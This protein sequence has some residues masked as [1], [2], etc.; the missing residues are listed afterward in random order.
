MSSGV[1][2]S[3]IGASLIS[4]VDDDGGAGC[5]QKLSSVPLGHLGLVLAGLVAARSITDSGEH[6]LGEVALCTEMKC[7]AEE[8]PHP[9]AAVATC[10]A[11]STQKALT[12]HEV[13]VLLGDRAGGSSCSPPTLWWPRACGRAG[14]HA[15]AAALDLAE[16]PRARTRRTPPSS[17]SRQTTATIFALQ[18]LHQGAAFESSASHSRL[19]RARIS[20]RRGASRTWTYR[21]QFAG[22]SL[23]GH[24]SIGAACGAASRLPP[25][26]S[27]GRGRS[28]SSDEV[29]EAVDRTSPGL[30]RWR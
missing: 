7:A 28:P 25:S 24:G 23:A 16:L 12:V 4:F 22:S 29:L 21:F 9:S 27:F 3:L 11:K 14:G 10:L 6:H 8:R 15:P 18:A 1:L 2:S 17:C 19:R 26:A 13:G 20:S 5:L 30:R